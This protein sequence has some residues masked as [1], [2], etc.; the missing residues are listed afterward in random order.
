MH[1]SCFNIFFDRTTKLQRQNFAN[2]Y[3]KQVDI[4][5]TWILRKFLVNNALSKYKL[6]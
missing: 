1:I 3:M 2:I 6:A 5:V 4:D